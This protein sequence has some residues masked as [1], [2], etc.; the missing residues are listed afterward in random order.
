MLAEEVYKLCVA[1]AE[2]LQID[3]YL[4]LALCEQE[5]AFNHQAVRMENG[6][7][8]K[9]TEPMALATTTEIL[10]ACSYGLGQV[11]GQVLREMGF[12]DFYKQ[13][14]NAHNTFQLT[15]AVSERAVPEAIN[16]FMVRPAWQVEWSVKKLKRCLDAVG[17]NVNNALLRYNGGGNPDYPVEV[18][19]KFEKLDRK[20]D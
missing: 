11:M 8:R 17:G 14:H 5:S 7:F 4:S 20:F 2:P 9:Y 18:M 19:K 12:F 10:L 16:A 13:Y 15:D 1:H 6:F 3:P